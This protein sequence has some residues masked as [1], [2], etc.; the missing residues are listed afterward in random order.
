MPPI[1]RGHRCANLAE[2]RLL[3]RDWLASTGEPTVSGGTDSRSGY[4]SVTIG[5][6]ECLL[7]G[8]TS[9]AGVE[10][11][12]ADTDAGTR[13]WVVPSRRGIQCQ[14]AFGTPPRVVPG[15]YL[16]T[17][18]PFGPP[19]ELDGPLV[20]PLR[21]LQGVAA[22][23]RRGHQQV[24][25]MPGM[26]PSGMYWRLNLTHATNLGESGAGF[27]QDRRATLDYTTGDGA[28]FA[29]IAVTAAT[30]P[31]QVADAVLAAR[32]HLARPE[33]D[34]A[35]AGWFAELL[36]LVE[37]QN[38]LPVAFADWFEESLGWEVGWGSGVRFPMPPRPGA[39]ATR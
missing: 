30:S 13:L 16:Y 23:H 1:S 34:W 25:I 35:Y 17:A 33:R 29:G 31:D 5:G 11:F 2:L 8:D 37:Q 9:R 4:V 36:G 6:V 7:A 14:V 39:D 26:S 19:Q 28:D 18:R 22:L 15:F 3:L 24:R 32:P 38:R 27:P 21:I 10:E 12:L 20:V